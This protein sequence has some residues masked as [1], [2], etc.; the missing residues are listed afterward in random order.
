LV[1]GAAAGVAAAFSCSIITSPSDY[2]G[3]DAGVSTELPE[4]AVARVFV[5]GGNR[6]GID[7]FSNPI[8]DVWLADLTNDGN[9][10]PWR[11]TTPLIY[12][13]SFAAAFSFGKLFVAGRTPAVEAENR[14]VVLAA[15]PGGSGVG[16][17]AGSIDESALSNDGLVPFVWGEF[18]YAL[19]GI[20]YYTDDAGEHADFENDVAVS[21][22]DPDAAAV[23]PWTVTQE[24]HIGRIHE[25]VMVHDGYFW[26]IAGSSSGGNLA[27]VE[28]ARIDAGDGMLEPFVELSPI[29]VPDAD[30]GIEEHRV[31]SP[32]VCS[33]GTYVYVVGGG[34]ETG[35]SNS[36]W[37]ASFDPNAVDPAA[38]PAATLAW[39]ETSPLPRGLEAARCVV[40]GD[41]ML[42][43]GGVGTSSRSN[44]VLQTTIHADGTLGEWSVSPHV[45][46]FGRSHV[47]AAPLFP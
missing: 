26:V 39:A 17:W 38:V 30:G 45:L 44:Q 4:N 16:E 3:G 14:F 47:A 20:Y 43:I 12:G 33:H 25:G 21:R 40:A 2:Q 32:A 8:P 35:P 15:A 22:L 6:D 24:L 18:I 23:L 9:I 19:G 31:S 42:I 41:W 5:L 46:P 36:V 27:H 13:G 29:G 28:A 7:D 11:T 1:L 10:G 34:T 37:Y